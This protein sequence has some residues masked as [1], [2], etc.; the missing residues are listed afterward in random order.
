MC[1]P[2]TGGAVGW[3]IQSQQDRNRVHSNEEEKPTTNKD[4]IKTNTKQTSRAPTK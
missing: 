2:V 3:G 4:L 1:T